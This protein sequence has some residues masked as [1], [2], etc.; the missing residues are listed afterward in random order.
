MLDTTSYVLMFVPLLSNMIVGPAL[1]RI[2][3]GEKAW[4]RSCDTDMKPGQCL[5]RNPAIPP[6]MVFSI[7]WLAL[8]MLIGVSWA[9]ARTDQDG[10]YQQTMDIMFGVL[11]GLLFLWTIV[12]GTGR[13]I[14]WSC[15]SLFVIFV[16]TAMQLGYMLPRLDTAYL[17]L[18]P[19]L[20]WETFALN[21]ATT[22]ITFHV[23]PSKYNM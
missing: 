12:F 10:L 14:R 15:Y 4:K 13:H 16:F 22:D 7:V 11:T 19:L 21:L 18:I 1:L 3:Y 8:F 6:G 23:K 17:Y 9:F 5:Q 20:C 2:M